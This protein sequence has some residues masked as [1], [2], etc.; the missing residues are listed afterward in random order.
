MLD[1]EIISVNGQAVNGMSGLTSGV[2]KENR[3]F[4]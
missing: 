1:E 4:E 3:R 2:S